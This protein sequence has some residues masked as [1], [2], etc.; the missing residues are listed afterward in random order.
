[1]VTHLLGHTPHEVMVVYSRDPPAS[2]LKGD[3]TQLHKPLKVRVGEDLG[4]GGVRWV[5]RGGANHS[6][7]SSLMVERSE[8]LWR[9]REAFSSLTGSTFIPETPV[10]EAQVTHKVVNNE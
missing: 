9:Q 3:L 7:T 5:R 1:M 4:R 8:I 10:R 2:N 6:L